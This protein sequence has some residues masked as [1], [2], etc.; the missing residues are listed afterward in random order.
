MT[1]TTS[2]PVRIPQKLL[3]EWEKEARKK[4][5]DSADPDEITTY[6]A[7]RAAAWG[8]T[9]KLYSICKWL[10]RPELLF[11]YFNGE[12]LINCLLNAEHSGNLKLHLY[13]RGPLAPACDD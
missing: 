12:K 11:E 13:R 3:N 7:T 5:D 8:A 9:E 4:F 1:T 10:D 6:I 2:P